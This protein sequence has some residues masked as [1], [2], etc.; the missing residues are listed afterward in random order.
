MMSMTSISNISTQITNNIFSKI[1][2]NNQGYI[3]KTDLT[4]ALSKING[5]NSESDSNEVFNN[6]DTDGDGKLTKSEL[7]KGIESLLSQLQSN[8]FQSSQGG[9][10]GTEGMPPPPPPKSE[11]DNGVTQDQASEIASSSDDSKLASLM[12]TV[13]ENFEAADTNE[14]GKVSAQ[15]AMAYQQK[16]E[17]AGNTT[18]SSSTSA[19]SDS[20]QANNSANNI[21]QQLIKAYGFNESSDSPFLMNVSA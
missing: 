17:A 3:D 1:D 5:S 4:S 15:E 12:K 6:M 14:D 20:A 18:S 8:A 21:I 10:G 13:S 19:T 2:T 7:S 9:M 16:S 11:G